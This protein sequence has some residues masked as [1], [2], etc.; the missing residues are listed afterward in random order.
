MEL[1][2]SGGSCNKQL[3]VRHHVT[4]VRSSRS[5]R[6]FNIRQQRQRSQTYYYDNVVQY[7]TRLEARVLHVCLQGGECY[8]VVRLMSDTKI[9]TIVHT[10]ADN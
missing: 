1:D 5:G 8:R 9:S 10:V 2:N 4:S 6:K 7:C 3:K